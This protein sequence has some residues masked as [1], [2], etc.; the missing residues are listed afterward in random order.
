LT[1]RLLALALSLGLCCGASATATPVQRDGALPHGG[2]YVIRPDG[3]AATASIALWFRAPSDGYDGATPG[4]AQLA[5]ATCAAVRLS[6]GKSLVDLVRSLGGRLVLGGEPDM[7]SVDVIVPA[8]S[9]RRVLAALTS[10]YFAP[11]PDAP[12]YALALRDSA[13][14]G[15]ERRYSPDLAM[16]DAMLAQ[17]VASG[18]AHVPVLPG[19]ADAF[20]AIP[21]ASVAAFAKRAF[22][23]PNAYL[24]LAGNVDA[25]LLDAVTDGDASA[26]A[27]SAPIDSRLGPAGT[28][29]T[30][31]A[32]VAGLAYGY[33]GPPIRDERAATALD[34]I[35]DYL[36]DPDRGVVSL[37]LR[38]TAA[39]VTG[40]FLTFH[41]PG[42]T[43]VSISGGDLELAG[44]KVRAAIAGMAT[45]LDAGTFAAA[46]R[47]F[48]YRT[49]LGTSTSSGLADGLA[50]YAV[51]GNA[52]YAPGDASGTYASA[53]AS[54]DPAYVASVARRYLQVPTIVHLTA[55]KGSS[56]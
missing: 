17:M 30:V 24:A 36:F 37:Q 49:A 9:A 21:L 39:N 52:T 44:T 33:A 46:R 47:A 54:L 25:T 11:A 38:D 7:T 41:D 6:G 35:S 29:A 40:H 34:F 8:G 27:T 45:P 15:V 48:V 26:N 14:R 10:A 51:Q 18:P 16:H 31:P 42:L 19:T 3:S 23:S 56:S 32:A 13:V 28:T 1:R 53:I 5:A 2:A 55:E 12:A 4:I 43:V 22:A 20:T 50:W